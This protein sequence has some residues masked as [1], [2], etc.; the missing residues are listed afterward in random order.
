MDNSTD[1]AKI[2]IE[3][4]KILQGVINRMAQNSLEC[5]K[6][7]LALAVGVLSLK[8]EAI[9]HLYG[10]CVLGVFVSMLLFFRRLLSHARK[11]V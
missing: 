7:T 6:W 11:V 10:L 3:E 4:L 5:K 1:R 9:S 8:I 2:L